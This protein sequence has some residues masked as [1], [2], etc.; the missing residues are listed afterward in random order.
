MVAALTHGREMQSIAGRE[1]PTDLRP[2]RPL[3]AVAAASLA[4]PK[5]LANTCFLGFAVGEFA[6][7]QKSLVAI[8]TEIP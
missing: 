5:A 6:S 3:E 8:E 4:K 1:H 2:N 7:L